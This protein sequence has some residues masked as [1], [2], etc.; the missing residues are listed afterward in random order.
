MQYR[1]TVLDAGVLVLVTRVPLN[2]RQIDMSRPRGARREASSA[3][4]QFMNT[5]HLYQRL[6]LLLAANIRPGDL[7][8]VLTYDDQHLPGSRRDV[9]ADFSYFKRRLNKLCEKNGLPRLTIISNIEYSHEDTIHKGRRWH[10]HY[11]ISSSENRYAELMMQ[12][13]TRG[14]V[15][16]ERFKLDPETG[17]LALAKYMCKD[18]PEY[19]GEHTYFLTQNAKKPVK[20]VQIIEADAPPLL[21]NGCRLLVNAPISTPG[22]SVQ[23]LK[24]LTA[25]VGV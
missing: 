2:G 10:I 21:P 22:G 4:Q 7:I 6:E 5:K 19:V 1:E 25:A 11:A 24:Y 15:L 8:G 18:A 20:D 12:A 9:K 16:R 23:R 14:I 13:W 17:Y 3:A